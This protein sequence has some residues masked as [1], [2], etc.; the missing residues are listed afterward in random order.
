MSA[1]ARPATQPAPILRVRDVEAGYR[2]DMP[3]LHGIDL[4]VFTGEVVTIIGP[5]G[6]GKSTLLKAIAGLVPISRGSVTYRDEAITGIAT[7]LLTAK[8]IACVPQT[9]NIF[10]KLSIRQNMTL[11]A[12]ALG[13]ERDERIAASMKLFPLLAERQGEKASHLSGGQRQMLAIAMATVTQPGLVMMDE[14]TAGLS[15]KIAGEVFADIRTLADS[16]VTV[17]LVEQNAKAAL[18][19]SDRAYVFAEGENRVDGRAADLLTDPVVGEIY[20]GVR[21]A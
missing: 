8:G 19:I 11:A 14:P 6:A 13:R 16:G 9:N 17:L 12:Y 18:A 1:A 4:D 5:N 15:P 2:A 20:L 3:V 7:H 21:R 10:A